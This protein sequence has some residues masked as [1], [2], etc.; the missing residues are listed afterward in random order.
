MT[1]FDASSYDSLVAAVKSK[2]ADELVAD[3]QASGGVDETLD[4][5]FAGMVEAFLPERAAGQEA[6][7]QYEVAAPDGPHPYWMRVAGGTC[8]IEPGTVDGPKATMRMAMGDFLRLVT[9]ALNPMSAVMTGKLKIAG[10]MFFLQTMQNWFDRP[11][12]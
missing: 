7:V 3:I 2:P 1:E 4:L 12:S 8:T 5:V 11:T 6:V 10:D 9:G